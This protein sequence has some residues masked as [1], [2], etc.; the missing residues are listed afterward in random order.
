MQSTYII[1]P[2]PKLDPTLH[3]SIKEE[4]RSPKA[5]TGLFTRPKI[6]HKINFSGTETLRAN[7]FP[8]PTYNYPRTIF[9]GITLPRLIPKTGE[10]RANS[11]N[12]FEASRNG[13]LRSQDC[14]DGHLSIARI[15]TSGQIR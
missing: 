5:D 13:F 3:R 4:K 1:K 14:L 6:S 10:K 7:Y 2:N 11:G 12:S 8:C 15:Y 9:S